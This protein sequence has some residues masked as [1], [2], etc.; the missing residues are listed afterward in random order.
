MFR[1]HVFMSCA[2]ACVIHARGINHYSSKRGPVAE[3]CFQMLSLLIMY[4]SLGAREK[5]TPP[6]TNGNRA[7]LAQVGS[8]CRR[9]TLECQCSPSQHHTTTIRHTYAHKDTAHLT[10]AV[11]PIDVITRLDSRWAPRLKNGMSLALATRGLPRLISNHDTPGTRLGM[12]QGIPQAS[13]KVLSRPAPR[14]R[15]EKV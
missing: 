13:P 15:L 5:S 1:V 4:C 6:T 12:P 2:R 8:R 7:T 3:M 11:R 9:P 10:L 14:T